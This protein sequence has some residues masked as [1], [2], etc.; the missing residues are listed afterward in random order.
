MSEDNNQEDFRSYLRELRTDQIKIQLS[1]GQI[2]LPE[3]RALA[4]LELERRQTESELIQSQLELAECRRQ[5]HNSNTAKWVAIAS[6]CAAVLVM[7]L[8]MFLG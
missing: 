2:R 4:K 5:L 1:L 8:T 7:A 3:D 6:A